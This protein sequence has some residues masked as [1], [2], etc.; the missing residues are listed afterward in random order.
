MSTQQ[1]S[2]AASMHPRPPIRPYDSTPSSSDARS[3]LTVPATARC[4][5]AALSDYRSMPL[6]LLTSYVHR[7]P[8]PSIHRVHVCLWHVIPHLPHQPRE[9]ATRRPLL[10]GFASDQV[11]K[12]LRG[13]E[14][15]L[16]RRRRAMYRRGR[17]CWRKR[18]GRRRDL[19]YEVCPTHA[20]RLEARHL[21]GL[22][23]SRFSRYSPLPG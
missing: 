21:G 8:T 16:D 7:S 2:T 9:E 10:L 6:I 3:K 14:V 1:S 13:L 15:D 11:G 18:G 17:Q 20:L 22:L 23:D 4:R 5:A 19:S 12:C